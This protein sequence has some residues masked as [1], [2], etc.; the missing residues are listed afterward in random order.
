MIRALVPFYIP[1]ILWE[2]YLRRKDR[3]PLHDGRRKLTGEK[4]VKI[5]KEYNF[6]Q[7][8]QTSRNLKTTI[9]EMMT[10]A[11]SVAMA[12]LFK[13]HGDDKNK[14]FRIAMPCNI[15]WK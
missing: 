5:S 11:L 4:I 1:I 2:S 15:R 10:S 6:Q 7:I 9:N 3:N 13:E 12:R 8:K 14:R